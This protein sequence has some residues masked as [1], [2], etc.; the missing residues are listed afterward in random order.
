MQS[1]GLHINDVVQIDEFLEHAQFHNDQYGDGMMV[2]I[3][4]HY[5]ALKKDHAIDHQK[6]NEDHE[7]LPFQHQSHLCFG[8][9]FILTSFK[10]E[11]KDI[12]LREFKEHNFYYQEPSSSLHLEGLFQ[13]PRLS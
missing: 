4:K 2:F 3:A 5:G 9:S 10:E 1:F 6:E 7:Q 8:S 12:E 13:P 11:F